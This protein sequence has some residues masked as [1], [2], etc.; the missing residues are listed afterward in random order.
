MDIR[1]GHVTHYYNRIGVAVLELSGNLSL[2]DQILILGH[3]TDFT[4]RVNSL[5]IEH[6]KIQSAGPGM[7]V[8]LKVEEPVRKGDGVYRVVESISA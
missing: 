3:N 7:E 8:A 5:E 2:G 6:K 1:I 4:Q